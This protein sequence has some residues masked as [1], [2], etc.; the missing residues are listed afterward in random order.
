MINMAC[1]VA[2]KEA[3]VND[4]KIFR[5]RAVCGSKA[6]LTALCFIHDV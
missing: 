2:C 3:L 4:I 1:E 5:W 6:A